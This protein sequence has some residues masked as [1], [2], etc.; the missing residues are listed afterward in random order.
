MR[1]SHVSERVRRIAL[2]QGLLPESPPRNP[3]VKPQPPAEEAEDKHDASGTPDDA[4]D[5]E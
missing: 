2:A 3:D 1:D 5:P 4:A